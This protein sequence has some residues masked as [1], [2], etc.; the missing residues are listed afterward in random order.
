MLPISSSLTPLQRADELLKAMTIEEKAFQLSSVQ[1]LSLF[2]PAGLSEEQLE[3]LL[4]QGIGQIAALPSLG[5]KTPS[6]LAGYVNRI[7]HFLVERTRPGIPAIVHCEALNGVLAPQFTSFPT[8]IGLA[9]TW[10][11]EGIQQMADLIRRQM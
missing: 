10:N 3:K 2:G 9:A 8:A 5:Y 11:P 4:G 7:Q 6:A 1:G